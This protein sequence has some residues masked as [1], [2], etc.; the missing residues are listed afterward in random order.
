[1]TDKESKLRL[2]GWQR[3]RQI[4]GQGHGRF[5]TWDK[6]DGRVWLFGAARVAANL[7]VTRLSGK[8]VLLPVTAVTTNISDFNAHLYAAW[9]SGRKSNNPISREVQESITSVPERTQRHY[10]Q[11]AKIKYQTNIAIGCKYSKEEVQKR[12]WQRGMAV[13][14][15]KDLQGQ[16]GI[17]GA[18]YVAWKLP[19]S[20]MGPHQQ[21]SNGRMRK[22]NQKLQVLAQKGARENGGEEVEKMYHANRADAVRALNRGQKPEAYWP[23]MRVSRQKNVWAVFSLV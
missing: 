8:P 9:H 6:G 3:L 4:L 15:F 11:V 16:Q 19:N 10:C 1:L 5:W 20:Y 12:A 7:E 2:F 14:E 13:F 21:T 17:K 23:M 18:S 22:I